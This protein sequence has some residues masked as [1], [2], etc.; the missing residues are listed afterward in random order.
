MAKI[1]GVLSGCILIAGIEVFALSKGIDGQCLAG[2]I[3]VMGGLLG[4]MIG[5]KS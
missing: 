5:K 3:G 1:V 2:S 4:W